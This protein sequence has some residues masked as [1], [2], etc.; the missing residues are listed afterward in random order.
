MVIDYNSFELKNYK[1][2]VENRGKVCS[3]VAK[4]SEVRFSPNLFSRNFLEPKP[5]PELEPNFVFS[6]EGSGSN[7]GS[8]PNFGNA[9]LK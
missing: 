3:P 8:G 1:K 6:P 5:E 4:G 9:N 2:N 7:R